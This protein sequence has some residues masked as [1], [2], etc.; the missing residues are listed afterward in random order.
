[1][2]TAS[3]SLLHRI[4]SAPVLP[5][6]TT[7][8]GVLA[9]H[10]FGEMPTESA[11]LLRAL[12]AEAPKAAALV[13]GIAAHAPFLAH[14]LRHDGDALIAHLVEA[15]D[16][17]FADLIAEVEAAAASAAEPNDL[18]PPLRVFRRRVATFLA[19]VDLGGVWGVE[20]V[21]AAL[22]ATADTAVRLTINALLSAQAARGKYRPVDPLDPGKGSGL[23]V[24]GLGKLGAGELNYSSDIDLVVFYD[25][26]IGE[27]SGIADPA[28]FFIRIARDLSRILQERTGDGYVFRVDLR[29]RPDPGTTPAA[30][31]LASAYS[32]Y[33][34]VGQNWERAAF[35][36]ARPIA[37][38]LACAERFLGD[39]APFIW[40]KYFD[41]AAIADIH[42]MKRQIQAFK[43][44]ETIAVAGHDVKLGRG[45]IREIE[46]F[47]QTQQLVFG[48]KRPVLRGRRTLDMLGELTRQGLISETAR[49]DLNVAYRHLRSIEHRLQMRLDEQ[50]Q[51]LPSDKADLEAFA[52]FCGHPNTA[53]FAAALTATA[54]VVER[55]Y[56]ML[57]EEGPSLAAD[58]G[59]LSFT[60]KTDDPQTLETLKRLGFRDP[61]RASDM[62]RGWHFG[63]RPAF[64]AVRAREVLTELT[65][66]LLVA[67]GRTADA[68]AALNALDN[69]FERMPAVVE[70]L[71]LLKANSAMLSLFCEILGSAPRLAETLSIHPHVLDGILDPDFVRPDLATSEAYARLRGAVGDPP[72]DAEVGLDRLR[73]AVRQER[74]LVGARMLS[75]LATPAQSGATSSAI[76]EAAIQVALEDCRRWFKAEHGEVPGASLAV[77]ALGRLGARELTATSDL[78]LIVTYELPDDAPRSTGERS[79]DPVVYHLRLTQRLIAALTVPTRRGRLYELDLR[80]R[81]AGSKGPVASQ[82]V[83]LSDY[84]RGDADLWEHMALTKA[85]VVAGDSPFTARVGDA[86]IRLLRQ[87]RDPTFVRREAAA[88]RALIAKEKGEGNSWDLKTASGGLTDIDF[89]AE[90]LLLSHAAKHP[91]LVSTR[92]VDVL[93][94]ARDAGLLQPEEADLLLRA[95]RLYDDVTQWQRFALPETGVDEAAMGPVLRRVAQ[96]VG[97]PDAKILKAEI[98]QTRAEVRRFF[99]QFMSRQ[100]P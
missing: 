16:R 25:A 8:D 45:G 34:T 86:L 55:H 12:L 52:R 97:V 77:I 67:L 23:L 2:E 28:P 44:H 42:A 58:A 60:G 100:Q 74:F 39:L 66:A 14:E 49:D 87:Q 9:R 50:T 81:P 53:A 82:L 19:L 17:R 10:V 90:V 84:F 31:S 18:M 61:A 68:D 76:A 70:L 69:A 3:Q 75:G 62:V 64:S 57:F 80:L 96:A 32:Y 99:T 56:A 1:M 5:A 33:E 98:D 43:G 41:F 13:A 11:D 92:S 54:Q 35:I 91:E 15:P 21:T 71:T 27:A 73:D 63:R 4:I 29:L 89:I 46:F 22:S 83:G 38:D 30:V 79:L 26:E 95:R 6:K 47:V 20:E 24:L 72:P 85:R 93:V 65:P 51:R 7:V 36:K 48:G 78:D 37:G 94:A 88:M 40:R 59:T